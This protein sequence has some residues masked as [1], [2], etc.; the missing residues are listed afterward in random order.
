MDDAR[1][2]AE[3][4]A[5]IIRDKLQKEIDD[6]KAAQEQLRKEVEEIKLVKENLEKIKK[7]QNAEPATKSQDEAEAKRE[8]LAKEA[9]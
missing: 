2:Q 7:E 5:Q 8:K 3:K 1:K 9:L 6:A 4:E